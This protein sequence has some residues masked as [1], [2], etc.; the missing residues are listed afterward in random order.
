MDWLISGLLLIFIIG[1][2]VFLRR[3]EGRKQ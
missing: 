1:V 3:R 2:L